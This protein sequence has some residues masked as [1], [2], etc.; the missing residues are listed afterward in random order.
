MVY[1][2]LP[3]SGA[4]SVGTDKTVED[5]TDKTV[6]DCTDKTVEDCTDKT[7]EDCTDKTVEATYRPS[8]H[9]HLRRIHPG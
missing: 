2:I 5:C 9:I 4:R 3:E 6:E 1:D 8:T 7:V